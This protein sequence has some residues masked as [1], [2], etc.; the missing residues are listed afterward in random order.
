MSDREEIERVQREY[1]DACNEG[2]LRKW[3][4]TLTEDAVVLPP[5]SPVVSGA[6][7]EKWAA[8]T[9]FDE[10]NNGLTLIEDEVE[11][12]GDWAFLR[13]RYRLS[14]TP[15]QGGDTVEDVGK[16]LDVMRRQDDGS[17]KFARL[18]WNSDSP[19]G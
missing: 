9:V 15:K 1:K 14:T 5:G 16:Y 2:D 3:M 8:E 17:W 7:I 6:E 12:F 4:S 10:F 13:G 19:A 11:V 18:A